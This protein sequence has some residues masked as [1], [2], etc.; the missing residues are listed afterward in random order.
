MFTKSLHEACGVFGFLEPRTQPLGRILYYGLYALQ[1]R[2]QES[3][4]M[5]VFD[6]DEL[7]LHKDMG[8]VNQV[9]SEKV[10]DKL[11]GQV[12]IGHTRYST[13]GCSNLENAQP[14]VARSSVGSITLAHNGNLINTDALRT[15]L[16]QAGFH[17]YGDSDSHMMAQAIRYELS[18]NPDDNTRH[19]LLPAVKKALERCKGAF[20]LVVAT[21]DS[22]IAAR[23]CNGLRP[24]SL[25]RM[26]TPEGPGAYVVASETCALDIVGATFVRDIMPGEIFIARLD[27]TTDSLFMDHQPKQNNLC[28]FELVYFARPDSKIEGSSIYNYRLELGKRLAKI[29]PVEADIVIPVPDSGNVAAVGYSREAGIAYVEGLIKNRYVGRTFISP[30]QALREQGI[31][32]KLN[33]MADVLAGKRVVVIDDSIVRGNTSRKLVAMLRDCGVKEIHLRISSAPVKNPCF[34]GIDMSDKAELIANKMDVEALQQW[35]GVDSLAYL[36]VEDMAAVAGNPTACMACFSGHYPAGQPIITQPVTIQD[37]PTAL[38]G[39]NKQ[40]ALL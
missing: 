10:L 11:V 33:P 22:L 8:L 4:G 20:S 2:G 26:M 38:V 15:F 37:D 40:A 27:G 18:H 35:L 30:T 34:Y 19:L 36:S 39:F 23:D 6:N 5:A 24:L 7:L 25:G 32:L 28:V 29:A 16:S 3:C 1:H 9:F 14:V 17:G 21:G 13:T 12:G 31:K